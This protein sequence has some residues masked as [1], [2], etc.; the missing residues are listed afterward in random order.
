M[1]ANHRFA[2]STHYTDMVMVNVQIEIVSSSNEQASK[3]ALVLGK[4]G[5]PIYAIWTIKSVCLGCLVV[6]LLPL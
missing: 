5:R 2:K 3:I 4:S 1:V 6:R